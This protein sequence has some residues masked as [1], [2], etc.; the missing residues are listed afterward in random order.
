M[1]K[2]GSMLCTQGFA[3]VHHYGIYIGHLIGYGPCVIHNDKNGGVQVTTYAAF[4]N[5]QDVYVEREAPDDPA[6]QEAI[7]QRASKLVGSQYN[8]LF[9]NCEDFANYV[10]TGVP[11]SKQV[12]GLCLIGL[13]VMLVVRSKSA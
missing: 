8:L 9:F 7:V 12:I 6:I 3:G 2:K 11:Y 13:V 1:T 5:G 10:Q 4:S